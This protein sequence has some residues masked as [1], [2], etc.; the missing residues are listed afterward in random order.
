MV[1]KTDSAHSTTGSENVLLLLFPFFSFLLTFLCFL[2]V[3]FFA[4]GDKLRFLSHPFFYAV[5][6]RMPSWIYLSLYVNPFA[7]IYIAPI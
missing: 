7:L 3:L 6:L 1:A 5:S 2:N 4:V